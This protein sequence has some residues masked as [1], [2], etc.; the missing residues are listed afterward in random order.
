MSEDV[1][2]VATGSDYRFEHDPACDGF[3]VF[4]PDGTK[5]QVP[6]SLVLSLDGMVVGS[7]VSPLPDEAGRLILAPIGVYFERPRLFRNDREPGSKDGPPLAAAQ[8]QAAQND[9]GRR[10]VLPGDHPFG[11][12]QARG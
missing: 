1:P 11:H 5:F 8:A 12:R 3:T 2:T 9:R 10:I 4:K 6:L 7:L